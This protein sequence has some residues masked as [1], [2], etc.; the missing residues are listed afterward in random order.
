MHASLYIWEAS[1]SAVTNKVS[2]ETL[3]YIYIFVYTEWLFSE[4][5]IYLP[6]QGPQIPDAP[7]FELLPVQ[8]GMWTLG[9]RPS[10]EWEVCKQHNTATHLSS[11]AQ[12]PEHRQHQNWLIFY[13]LPSWYQSI[14]SAN[15]AINRGLRQMALTQPNTINLSKSS[16]CRSSQSKQ[17]LLL[18]SSEKRY[19]NYH[20]HW[21][22][23][24]FT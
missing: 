18:Q 14:H 8:A 10:S 20:N 23:W 3:I 2:L 16:L 13:F 11:W 22:A 17:Y 4:N 9:S 12:K 24:F 5:W 19:N 6:F 1:F 21:Y 7:R 15:G